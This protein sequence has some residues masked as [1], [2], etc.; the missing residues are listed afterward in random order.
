MA[1]LNV[2]HRPLSASAALDEVQE[3][4]AVRGRREQFGFFVLNVFRILLSF[5]ERFDL[6]R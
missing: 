3:V 1:F 4:S 5:F 2:R 6:F